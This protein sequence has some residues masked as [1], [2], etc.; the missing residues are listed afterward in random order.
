MCIRLNLLIKNKRKYLLLYFRFHLILFSVIWKSE[1]QCFF[2]CFDEVKQH[3]EAENKEE[4]FGKIV[5]LIFFLLCCYCCFIFHFLFIYLFLWIF[6][7]LNETKS[8]IHFTLGSTA[9]LLLLL[10]SSTNTRCLFLYFLL[11]KFCYVFRCCCFVLF[12]PLLFNLI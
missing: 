7:R 5:R 8:I 3:K 12:I 6:E 1:Y 2:G 10:P 4:R 9:I 11:L